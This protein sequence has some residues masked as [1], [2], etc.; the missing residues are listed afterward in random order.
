MKFPTKSGM[1]YREPAGSTARVVLP[2]PAPA[3]SRL[4]WPPLASN[5][6]T[7]SWE[8]KN[9]SSALSNAIEVVVPFISGLKALMV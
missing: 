8:L 7:W 2:P 3:I 9:T 6:F 4:D 1:A 5:S